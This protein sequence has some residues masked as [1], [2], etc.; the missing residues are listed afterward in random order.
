[1][2]TKEVIIKTA[3]K[4]FL[5]K[6]FNETSMN[7]I[8]QEVGVSKPAIYHHFKNKDELVG[9]IFDYFTQRITSWGT[10]YF[11]D[12]TSDEQKVHRMFEA[13]PLFMQI[14]KSIIG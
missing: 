9:A 6:G 5:S 13:A 10:K 14:E 7:E 2:K 1:M 12:C 3:L 11:A 8:A 4:L